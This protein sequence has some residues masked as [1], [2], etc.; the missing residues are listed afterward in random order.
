MA[1]SAPEQRPVY[2]SGNESLI[3]FGGPGSGKTQGQV[4]PN[5][6]R[7]PG[8]AF[9][10]DVK[11]ELYAETAEA[12]RA[13]GPVYRFAPTDEGGNTH[14][15]N[16]FDVISSEPARAAADCQ[17]LADELISVSP[18]AREPYWE[19]KARDMVWAFSVAV[20]IEAPPE[21]RNL[22][23]VSRYLSIPTQFADLKDRYLRSETKLVV[24]KL[25]AMGELT[26]L[27]ELVTTSTAIEN[28]LAAQRL[29]SIFDTARSQINSIT[30]IPSANAALS[31]SDWKPLDLRSTP[32]TTVYFSLRPGELKAFAPLVRLVFSQHVAALTKDFTRRPGVPP[33]T[34]FLDEMPQ[35]GAMPGL[36]DIIDVGRGAGL[37][38][39]MFAQ[40]LGQLR[41][42]Y[43]PKADGLINACAVRSFMQPDLD[44]AR[45]VAPQLGTTRHIFTGEQKPLAEPHDL[46]GRAFADDILVARPERASAAAYEALR[47]HGDAASLGGVIQQRGL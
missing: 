4:I 40:Y 30:R 5:L 33:V 19:R 46:T 26:G 43:G 41:E 32:G 47:I 22:A 16:P 18:Q 7:Y 3:T 20:A 39:W 9:V 42:I 44:A 31:A 8:S 12:R 35:L 29:E 23:E 27:S 34:F 1:I 25:K 36:S 38:L 21:K 11:G 24:A 28:G 10:L 2:F 14:R 13:F 15:Y 6:L 17:V 45:F 37:R